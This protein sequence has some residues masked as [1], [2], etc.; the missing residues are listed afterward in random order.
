MSAQKD[1]KGGRD[2]YG[3]GM[4]KTETEFVCIAM[5][6]ICFRPRYNGNR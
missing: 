6:S 5:L 3:P 2:G 1:V 4:T